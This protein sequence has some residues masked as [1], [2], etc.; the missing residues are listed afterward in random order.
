M[1][2]GLTLML[3]FDIVTPERAAEGFSNV[4]HVGAA[5][6]LSRAAWQT[7]AYMGGA[8][9]RYASCGYHFGVSQQYA[10]G[11]HAHTGGAVVE[12][13]SKHTSVKAADAAQQRS[14]ARRNCDIAWNEHKP[15]CE[16][17]GCQE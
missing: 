11:C 7:A 9:T 13:T 12:Q 14:G 8:V 1:L 10:G 6:N 4:A 5:T 16:W 17:A 3:A 2:L 15:G